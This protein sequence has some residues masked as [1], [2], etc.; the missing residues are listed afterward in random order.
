[1][2]LAQMLAQSGFYVPARE[3]RLAWTPGLFV[4][5]I[6]EARADQSE[7]R[8]G[9]ELIRIRSVFERLGVGAMVILDE[10]CSGTNPKEGEEIFELVVSLLAE[11]DPQ[12]FITTHFLQF[13][14]RLEKERPV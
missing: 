14:S 1:V 10:L 6:E 12:A 3:A 7:G 9:M 11:L 13:A 2:A 4:S 8:L 5:F